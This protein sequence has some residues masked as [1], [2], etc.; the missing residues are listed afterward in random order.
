MALTPPRAPKYGGRNYSPTRH[1]Q[2]ETRN[3][4][5]RD[6]RPAT[7]RPATRR[8]RESRK[9]E[10][11]RQESRKQG[12]RKQESKRQASRDQGSRHRIVRGRRRFVS[13]TH[14][15]PRTPLF[16]VEVASLF[17]WGEE[18]GTPPRA[19]GRANIEEGGAG[20]EKFKLKHQTRKRKKVQVL[21]KT[22]TDDLAAARYG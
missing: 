5:T 12:S 10:S 1:P 21:T 19:L 17:F 15:T 11:E 9:Q 3:P 8:R 16:N 20:G 4:E 7:R 13:V 18:G 14:T 2:L 22:T 6:R